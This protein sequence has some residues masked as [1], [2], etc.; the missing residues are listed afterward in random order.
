MSDVRREKPDQT[1]RDSGIAKLACDAWD[2]FT[3]NIV[4]PAVNES[5]IKTVNTVAN[6]VN[7][8]SQKA[9][10]T[11]IM[12]KIKPLHVKPA[13]S[14]GVGCVLQNLS[15]G[16]G[17]MVPYV[18]AG[19][20]MGGT[21]RLGGRFMQLEGGFAT[22]LA[23]ERL[24][25]IG[26][27]AAFDFARDTAPGEKRWSNALGGAVAFSIIGKGNEVAMTK[28]SLLTRSIYRMGAGAL[29]ADAQMLIN[30]AQQGK[31]LD[32]S[33]ASKLGDTSIHGS[34]MNIL[35][36]WA[37]G[38]LTGHVDAH[39]NNTARSGNASGRGIPFSRFLAQEGL[40]AK[41]FP[42]LHA[43]AEANPLA[44][45]M[46]S[47]ANS[48]KFRKNVAYIDPR[49]VEA[50]AEIRSAQENHKAAEGKPHKTTE[51]IRKE[52]LARELS[53]ELGDIEAG[54]A[55]K[56]G[57]VLSNRDIVKALKDG[58]VQISL[59]TGKEGEYAPVDFEKLLPQIGTNSLDLTL[60]DKFVR[61]PKDRVLDPAVEHPAD[62]LRGL[63][64]EVHPQGILL[65][66][67]EFVLA[68]SKEKITLPAE[69]EV[70]WNGE[71][72]VKGRI[73]V[74]SSLAR[75]GIPENIDAPEINCGTDNPITHEIKNNGDS[76][77]W[78]RPGM[79]FASVTFE[80]LSGPPG[81]GFQQSR[82][83]GQI[84]PAGGRPGSHEANPGSNGG[85][86]ITLT[87]KVTTSSGEKPLVGAN[88]TNKPVSDAPPNAAASRPTDGTAPRETA[89]RS[90]E[91]PQAATESPPT[92][93][94]GTFKTADQ[95]RQ[96]MD[97]LRE[98]ISPATSLTER[99]A[100]YAAMQIAE[101]QF[102]AETLRN[103]PLEWDR[104]LSGLKSDPARK[105]EYFAA[106]QT[107]RNVMCRMEVSDLVKI[108]FSDRVHDALKLLPLGDPK[109]SQ[110]R[111]ALMSRR[112]NPVDEQPSQGEP[113]FAKSS[114]KSSTSGRQEETGKDGSG[115]ERKT[116]QVK[117]YKLDSPP[118]N[119][120][121]LPG[122]MEQLRAT[123]DQLRAQR[124]EFSSLQS[125]IE[126]YER[127]FAE[128]ALKTNPKSW[129]EYMDALR[130]NP[131]RQ[132]DYADSC[133]TERT[134]LQNMDVMD[135]LKVEGARVTQALSALNDKAKLN[136]YLT[137]SS[138][139]RYTL[140][141]EALARIHDEPPP[142]YGSQDAPASDNRPRSY[143]Q[144]KS[145]A[146][147]NNDWIQ[148]ILRQRRK[149]DLNYFGD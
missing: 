115:Q 138:D 107:E 93:Q 148:D 7:F 73:H 53:A 46:Y 48:P 58:R 92:S 139:T 49:I 118:A 123:R 102:A 86:K 68:W 125:S 47:E 135:L 78:L 3:N 32:K 50:T 40:T 59:P 140:S 129:Y 15:G 143:F 5:C 76:P 36:P 13:E 35:L 97:T 79:R 2:G 19:K 114:R 75:W 145:R 65:M 110:Y 61:L 23:S 30:Q 28:E 54:R 82:M 4:K 57:S 109:G 91:K 95:F 60:G 98:N 134:V 26:G 51:Q 149:G 33:T 108:P 42:Q 29:G 142:G 137:L 103:N 9:A 43:M 132:S 17:A 99:Q 131:T 27:A 6:A 117:D 44:R 106:L 20:A 80:R 55:G 10:D 72:P 112:Y 62:V 94:A 105:S 74:Q 84:D 41:E 11:D 128:H 16:L 71:P 104:Y 81:L 111:E 22:V 116:V 66:P 63:K 89:Y 34:A 38:K 67:G 130:R 45:V 96:H 21:M 146:P 77:V 8:I 12:G 100:K 31:L 64:P 133:R 70:G 119:Q 39:F 14:L 101:R 136:Q 141:P 37:H 25:A 52:A 1:A 56:G 124:L 120:A 83:H 126:M 69:Q 122:Y 24:A 18:L 144:S 121:E 87:D 113:T 85:G 127:Q 147:R 88:G 90:P